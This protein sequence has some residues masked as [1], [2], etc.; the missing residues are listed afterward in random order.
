MAVMAGA[1]KVA[2][3]LLILTIFLAA[4]VAATRPLEGSGGWPGNNAPVRMVTQML[5]SG[6][7]GPNSIGH[8]CG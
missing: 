2:M 4:V 6:S 8:C 1:A 5:D 7:S 3:L